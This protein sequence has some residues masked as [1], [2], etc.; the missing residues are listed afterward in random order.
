MRKLLHISSMYLICF[1]ALLVVSTAD[2]TTLKAMDD[3]QLVK[4]ADLVVVGNVKDSE[5][6]WTEFGTAR[7]IC[8]YT[9]VQVTEPVKASEEDKIQQGKEIVVRTLGGVVGPVGCIVEGMPNLKK[10]DQKV[11]FLKS[12]P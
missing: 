4:T 3:S 1:V 7:I 10:G 11:L 12:R 8:T 5:A 2:A 6:R 9:T